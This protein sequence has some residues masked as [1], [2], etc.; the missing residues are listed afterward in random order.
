MTEFPGR[1]GFVLPSLPEQYEQT[2][3]GGLNKVGQDAITTAT[4]VLIAAVPHITSFDAS[5]TW[6][7]GDKALTAIVAGCAEL[8]HLD[9]GRSASDMSDTGIAALAGCKKLK[10]LKFT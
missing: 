8:E 10:S 2:A 4:I 1:I 7:L 5:E 3:G 6:S 9:L